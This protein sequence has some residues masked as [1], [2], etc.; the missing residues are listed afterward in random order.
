M[1]KP[2]ILIGILLLSGIVAPLVDPPGSVAALPYT[3]V[4]L[5]QLTRLPR[6]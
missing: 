4:R 5:K 1:M 3:R 6:V 2:L